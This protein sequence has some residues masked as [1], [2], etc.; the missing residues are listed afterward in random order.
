MR[1]D[2]KVYS[3]PEGEVLVHKVKPYTY[4]F[5][6]AMPNGS[7][8]DKVKNIRAAAKDMFENTDALSLVGDV[9]YSNKRA[10]E[11]ALLV[12]CKLIEENENGWILEMKIGDWI[13]D[14]PESPAN[15]KRPKK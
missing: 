1:K 11:V 4:Y 13:K 12:G 5:T 8:E 6:Y 7:R 14:Y 3:F 10:V 9:P 15:K 2:T